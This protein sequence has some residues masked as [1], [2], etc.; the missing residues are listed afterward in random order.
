MLCKYRRCNSIVA[1]CQYIRTY[2]LCYYLEE[3]LAYAKLL[4]VM[5]A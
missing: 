1:E 4:N 5:L 3:S 2:N